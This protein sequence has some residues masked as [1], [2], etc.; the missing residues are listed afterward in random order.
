MSI[1]IIFGIIALIILLWQVSNLVSVIYGCLYVATDKILI[2]KALKAANL[3]KEEIF[4][5]L[6]CGKGDVLI[7]AE[8]MGVRTIGYEISPYYY[9]LAK[10]KTIRNPRIEVRFKNIF[11]ADLSKADIVYCYLIPKFLE[12]I[13][14]KFKK[15]MKSKARIISISFPLKGLSLVYKK[16]HFNKTIYIYRIK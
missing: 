8:K 2:K 11:Q 10:I 12:K 15:E 5:D 14:P 7:E 3:K 16:K 1:I 9:I 6:G 13:Y 4:Y